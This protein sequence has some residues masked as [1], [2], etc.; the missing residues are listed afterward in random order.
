LPEKQSKS[1]K[2][3]RKK[4]APKLIQDL[5]DLEIVSFYEQE[6][7]LKLLTDPSQKDEAGFV[8]CSVLYVPEDPTRTAF[9]NLG[10]GER[11]GYYVEIKDGKAVIGGNLCKTIAE[12]GSGTAYMKPQDDTAQ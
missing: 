10:H 12:R 11:R 2:Q 5:D 8:P 6:T 7:G 1:R 3:K 9:I 4:A